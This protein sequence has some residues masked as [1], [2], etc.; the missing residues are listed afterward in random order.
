MLG[1]NDLMNYLTKL[2]SAIFKQG[3]KALD[4][5][6]LTDGFAMTSN[7]TVIF[8][9]AFHHCTTTMGWNQGPRQITTFTNS[10]GC[11]VNIIKSYGQI[12]RAALKTAYERFCKPGE[13]DSQTCA[14][15]NNTMMSICL[16]KITNG[17]RTSK[18]THL[19]I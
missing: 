7:Q 5:K 9:E 12:D 16:A 18:T 15:Q 4:N 10:A 1:A 6:P 11:Q 13:P 14:K 3:C 17:R 8:V 2:G 19:Q